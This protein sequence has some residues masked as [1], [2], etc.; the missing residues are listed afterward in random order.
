MADRIAS[1]PNGKTWKPV[2]SLEERLKHGLFP[3]WLYLA[4]RVRK[5]LLRG[6]RELRL[7]PFL[8]DTSRV[9]LDVGANKGIW[10]EVLR[11]T[12]R[13]VHAFEPN[14]KMFALLK[15][16][17]G[18]NVSTH[19]LALSNENGEAEFRIP[20]S[21]KGGYSNQGGSLSKV[22]VAENY[23][24]IHVQTARLDDMNFSDIGF[25]KI[26]VEGSELQVL[27]GAEKT[28]RRNRPVMVIEIEER[29]MKRPLEEAISI[30]ESYGYQTFALCRGVL[31][32]FELIDVDAHHRNSH[33]NRDYIN[34]FI[35]LP[36]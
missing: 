34:N 9:A 8:A 33:A 13:E 24:S 27:E 29:H 5:E 26:D 3:P 21:R 35:F 18:K 36:T 23:G 17:A 16:G 28:I 14:P 22:K 2:L 11:G 19:R 31:T 20:R 32:S 25:I 30:V 15:A 10:T 1:A 7:V 12:C 4:Y 6:E